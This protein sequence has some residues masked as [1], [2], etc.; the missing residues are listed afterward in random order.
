MVEVSRKQFS[1]V[2][3]ECWRELETAEGLVTFLELRRD[4]NIPIPNKAQ[5]LPPVSK[6]RIPIVE[7]RSRERGFVLELYCCCFVTGLL[8]VFCE[9]GRFWIVLLVLVR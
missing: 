7:V 6:K 9:A 5:Q 8:T 4:E 2:A 3:E 1:A